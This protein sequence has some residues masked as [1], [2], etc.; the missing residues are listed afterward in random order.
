MAT[1]LRSGL[2]RVGN[3]LRF[4]RRADFLLSVAITVAALFFLRF[5]DSPH[6]AL[7]FVQNIELRSLD[8]RFLLRGPRPHDDDIVIVGL[9]ENTLQKVGAFPF[10]R[11]AYARMVDQLAKGGAKVIA[12]DANFPVPENNSALD[13]LQELEHGPLSPSPAARAKIAELERTHNNDAIFGDSIRR[14]G[15][16]VLGH[17]F[18]DPERAKS[19]S[20]KRAETYLT[21][22]SAHPFPQIQKLSN[23]RAFDVNEAWIHNGG[24]VAQGVYSNIRMLADGAK[25][26]GF[27][28]D[29]PD[30]DGAF[31]RAILLIRYKE[32]DYFP[33]LA[34]E[35]VRQ[36]KGITDQ[37]SVAYF[38]EHGLERIEIGPYRLPAQR[39]GR[40]LINFAGPYLSYKHY[41]MIDVIDGALPPETFRNKIVLFGATAVAIGDVRYIPYSSP[42][43]MGAEVH[44]HIIDNILHA[45]EPGR[46]F[47]NRGIIEESLD[48]FFIL[49]FGLAFGYLFMRTRPLIATLSGLV[50]LVVFSMLVYFAFVH[51]AMWLAF[52]VPAG[53]LVANYAGITS[54]RMIFEER[55]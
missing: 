36:A 38:G 44:A 5:I 19:V 13:V 24:E 15:N 29:E 3:R 52:V 42:N 18:L 35:T 47:L 50:A 9:D 21:I 55:E 16:V 12:F 10:P 54:F 45:Q 40:A 25:S 27:F 51:A 14:A 11:D 20:E 2:R 41:S 39:D 8:A 17:L 22:L 53:T 6:P 33:S 30:N 26:F 34:L 31:R 43:Y 32:L 48:V 23:G 7:R 37:D 49:L 46:G 1:V 28:D 4:L